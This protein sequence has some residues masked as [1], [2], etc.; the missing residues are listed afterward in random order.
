MPDNPCLGDLES[1]Q[2]RASERGFLVSMKR[3]GRALLISGLVAASLLTF[4]SAI[5]WMVALWLSWHTWLVVR[6]RPGW[7][8]L[9]ACALIL[10][11]K[12]P[13]WPPGT[14]VLIAMMLAVTLI[15]GLKRRG[16]FAVHWRALT[17]AALIGLWAAWA[18]AAIEWHAAAHCTRRVAFEPARPIVCLGDSLTAGMS[19]SRGYPQVLQQMICVGV[20]NLGQ[21]G[22]TSAQALKKLPALVVAN[23]QAVVVEI[24]G[25][26]FLKGDGR[27]V[28]KANVER[29]I[30]ACRGIGAEVILMEVPRGFITDPY[31]GLERELA[32]R[33]DLEL[34]SDTSIRKLVLWSPHAPP[35][36]WLGPGWH[37]SDDGLHPNAR[38][39]RVLAEEVAES[40]ARLFG[41]RMGVDR[42]D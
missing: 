3:S 26:D 32:R 30:G 31:A 7:L 17:W 21:D 19:P 37:L 42:E 12:R 10:L 2:P 34:V 36:I 6:R 29:I 8:P 22:I 16:V 24:G 38:G 27:A 18:V 35:G 14:V 13:A 11:A 39:N 33:H 15:R 1:R 4:P 20:V 25:H 41:P 40:L 23:P 9:V 28:T 5:P